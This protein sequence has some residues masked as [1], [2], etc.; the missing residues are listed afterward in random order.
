MLITEN[1]IIQSLK[2]NHVEDIYSLYC[3]EEVRSFLGGVPEKSYIYSSFDSM[4]QAPFPNSYFYISLKNNN[5][6]IG[7]VSIDEYHEKTT[8]ELSYQFLPQYWGKGYAFEVLLAIIHYGFFSLNLSKI[9][10]ETQTANIAS[11]RVLEK[12]GMQKV[13]VLKRFGHEQAVFQLLKTIE[14]E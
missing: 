4:L 14:K 3:N 2:P 10:A 7:L 8:Y 13:K 5:E 9:V 11:C 1:C 12:L 6:F